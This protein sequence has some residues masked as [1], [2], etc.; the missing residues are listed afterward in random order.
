MRLQ[1]GIIQSVVGT[2]EEGYWG[3][4]GPANLALIGEAYGCDFDQSDNLYI[5]DG[6]N[7]TVRRIDRINWTIT[8]VAGC[9]GTVA[10]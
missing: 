3:D 2:G 4:D 9:G 5:S 1:K 7:H 6:R 10:G 8:T